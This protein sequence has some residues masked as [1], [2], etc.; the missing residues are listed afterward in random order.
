MGLGDWLSWRKKGP[1]LPS[2]LIFKSTSAAFEYA[3]EFFE[4]EIRPDFMRLA[5]VRGHRIELRDD[6][7]QTADIL[8]AG[9]RDFF[10]HHALVPAR[11]APKLQPLD[12][13]FWRPMEWLAEVDKLCVETGVDRRIA[14]QGM[15]VGK[16]L[17]ELEL[18][19][20]SFTVEVDY[21]KFK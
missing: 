19:T 7:Y 21:A 18:K 4:P 6:G 3:C 11:N 12:L 15:I 5:L 14:W 10:L 17:P 1:S 20:G 13:V 9:N 2:S 8:I 16:A